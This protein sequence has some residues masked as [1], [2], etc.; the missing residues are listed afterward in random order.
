MWDTIRI[1]LMMGLS[2]TTPVFLAWLFYFLQKKSRF[3]K[4]DWKW[5]QLIIG[6][7][8]GGMAIFSTQFGV[9]VDAE[10]GVIMNV[11]D[12]S[13]MIAG[14]VFGGPAGIIAGILGGGYRLLYSYVF[15]H[16]GEVTALSGTLATFLA[17]CF[18]AL[19]RHKT[20]RDQKP[21]FL[22]AFG[23]GATMEVF[24]MLL[25][26]VCNLRD[27][28]YAFKF[29]QMCA[30]GMILANAIAISAACF[31]TGFVK[32]KEPFKE[33]RKKLSYDVGFRL[34][35]CVIG[36]FIITSAFTAI[37]VSR[38]N[39][40]AE[41]SNQIRQVTI[42]LIIFMEILIYC[43]IFMLVYQILND[44]ILSNMEKINEGLAKISN[45]ELDTEINVRGYREF[46]ELSDDVN[47]TVT[48]LKG[49]IKIAEERISKELE[50]AHQIQHSSLPSVFPPYPSR[51][52]FD[53]Y[54]L[55]DA[56][57]E[58]GGDFYDFY[59]VEPNSLVILI[60]DV[61]GKGVPAAM[62]M[63]NSKALIKG[64]VESGKPLNEAISEA[65]KKLCAN[66]EAEMFVTMWVGKLDL[67]N[68]E[69]E[70]V[71][72]GHNPPIILRHNGSTEYL[73]AKVNFVLGGF[74]NSPYVI[75]KLTLY[76]GDEIFLYT[77]GV[78]EANDMAKHQFGEGR[79]L[80]LLKSMGPIA[81]NLLSEKVKS[82]V[83]SFTGD[84]PKSDDITILSMRLNA[85]AGKNHVKT[86]A[87][88][89]S[90]SIVAKFID[91]RLSSSKFGPLLLGKIQ[92]A[93]DEVF[94]N[95]A[96]Y[97]GANYIDT[98]LER[99][100]V[101]FDLTFE[102]DGVAFNPL[103]SEDPDI[104]LSAKDRQIGGLG[105]LMLKKL[106][107]DMQYQRKGDKNILRLC[108]VAEGAHNQESPE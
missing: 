63:M 65:N 102:D 34:L 79:L 7:V 96:S 88:S 12:A 81:P 3:G 47:A 19:L 93:A 50:V 11:R 37:V 21:N 9:R 71:N 14:L 54:A 106:T 62:F 24:H 30:T 55:M 10:A 48:S 104:T 28:D 45:G 95:I 1:I 17:G 107:S 69:M 8:Y 33:K 87:E 83:A 98:S 38:V 103:E 46:S 90:L 97:S 2:T 78:T 58:V 91:E 13:P 74:E 75:Q 40:D 6:L 51:L 4:L 41:D 22:A 64:L 67:R 42:Y 84:A 70:Y 57:K 101:G 32:D 16:T 68:G 66:N 86:V 25:V 36:C 100:D 5:Q 31:V 108:F 85:C 56:A 29:V 52:D 92:V 61:S 15:F 82:E 23:L 39:I 72:A 76:P 59:L 105:I 99:T 18:A 73:K 53:V 77:D 35:A 60:A 49:Y 94:S 89:D 80:T 43:A 20:F 44:K 26:L 27:I